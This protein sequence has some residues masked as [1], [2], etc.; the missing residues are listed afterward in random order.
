MTIQV[1]ISHGESG[2]PAPFY[3]SKVNTAGKPCGETMTVRDGEEV[4]L[5]VH[6]DQHLVV[7]ERPPRNI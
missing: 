5:Y 4:K 6:N 1:K 2:V 7:S 3:V